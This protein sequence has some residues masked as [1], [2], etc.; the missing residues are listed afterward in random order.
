MFLQPGSSVSPPGVSLLTPLKSVTSAQSLSDTVA[1][2]CSCCVPAAASWRRGLTPWSDS[3]DGCCAGTV[4]LCVR[5]TSQSEQMKLLWCQNGCGEN[6][7]NCRLQKKENEMGKSEGRLKENDKFGGNG[8]RRVKQSIKELKKLAWSGICHP[9]ER[10]G[11]RASSHVSSASGFTMFRALPLRGD[12]RQGKGGGEQQLG[13][14]TGGQL[15]GA[16]PRPFPPLPLSAGL[17]L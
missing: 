10:Q 8:E 11:K 12:W 15:Q 9:S 14:H 6:D 17:P 1:A 2:Q 13:G 7:L 3:E 4:G 5:I 16:R